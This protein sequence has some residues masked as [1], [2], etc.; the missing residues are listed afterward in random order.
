MQVIQGGTA[1]RRAS[2]RPQIKGVDY[3]ELYV[4][5]ARQAAHF[6]R[7]TFGFT[8]VAYA[9]FETG[10]RDQV[11]FVL[12]QGDMRLILTGPTSPDS[13]IARHV[14]FHGDSVKNIAF[15][16]DDVEQTF[17]A[18]L[19]RGAQSVAEPVTFEDERGRFS[20]ATIGA[21]GDTVHSFVQRDSPDDFYFPQY[22]QITKAPFSIPTGVKTLDHV[23]VSIEEG[24]LDE[25]VEFY[26]RVL[27]FHES[28]QEN[29]ESEYSAMNSKVVQNSTG[30]VKFPLVCPAPSKRKSQIEEYLS[31]HRGPGVQHLAFLSNDIID[32]VR[33]VRAGAIDFLHPPDAYYE[34]L[35]D[36][37]GPIDYDIETLRELDIL[38]DRD[39]DGYLMQIFTKPLD[40]R[41]TMFVEIIQR[42]GSQG[43]GGGN[44]KSLFQAVEREQA[45]RGNL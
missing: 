36:R 42:I 12:Q 25:W 17:E 44:I 28:H 32:T 34:M 35:E 11:S 2:Q 13:P 21:Y 31:F 45:L 9:D 8:P 30:S 16:V 24:R 27:G 41:P 19:R 7:T 29:V 14:H 33:T 38:V 20:K 43:F 22:N 18:S 15:V 40:N 5:N 4:G 26:Q 37:I 23:A 1:S 3:V 10:A 6:Y 39:A